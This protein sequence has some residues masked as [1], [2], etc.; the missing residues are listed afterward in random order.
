MIQRDLLNFSRTRESRRDQ[1][2]QFFWSLTSTMEGFRKKRK[3]WLFDQRFKG[4]LV[5]NQVSFSSELFLRSLS[6][7]SGKVGLSRV[8]RLRLCVEEK[9]KKACYTTN[10]MK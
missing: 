4:N 5:K 2:Y 10:G 7:L 8:L 3:S 6:V 9:E 1:S